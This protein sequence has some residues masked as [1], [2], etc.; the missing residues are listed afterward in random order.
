MNTLEVQKT[1]LAA[2]QNNRKK[3]ITLQPLKFNHSKI[4]MHRLFMKTDT[5]YKGF[6]NNVKPQKYRSFSLFLPIICFGLSFVKITA[7]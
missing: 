6:K 1:A 4:N 7:V 3:Q 5:N 2:V